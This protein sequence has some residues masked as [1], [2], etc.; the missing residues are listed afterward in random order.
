MADA[1][2]LLS[3]YI[4][5]FQ[6]LRWEIPEVKN[7]PARHVSCQRDSESLRGYD[8]MFSAWSLAKFIPRNRLLIPIELKT[9]LGFAR[10]HDDSDRKLLRRESRESF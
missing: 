3:P 6:L 7:P 4:E 10:N 2:I 9:V 5:E 8:E 1:R